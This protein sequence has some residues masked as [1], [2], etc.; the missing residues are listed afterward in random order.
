MATVRRI[1]WLFARK[2]SLNRSTD[3]SNPAFC[4]IRRPPLLTFNRQHSG[5]FFTGP[6]KSLR[7]VLSVSAFLVLIKVQLIFWGADV[8]LRWLANLSQFL[9]F[10]HFRSKIFFGLMRMRSQQFRRVILNLLS[11]QLPA[12]ISM[13]WTEP[14]RVQSALPTTTPCLSTIRASLNTLAL[15]VNGLRNQLPKR[16]VIHFTGLRFVGRHRPRPFRHTLSIVNWMR[17]ASCR[18]G[19]AI[20]R[21]KPNGLL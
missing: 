11:R 9:V 10:L 21:T 19:P 15:S 14:W 5:K 4:S 18:Y 13:A 3:L 16:S 8:F 12:P 6:R 7:T 1:Y 20:H 17:K 2:V